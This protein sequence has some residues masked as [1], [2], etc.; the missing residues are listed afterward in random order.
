MNSPATRRAVAITSSWS[1]GVGST[2]AAIL[3][4]HE[5]PSTSMPMCRATIASVL[6]RSATLIASPGTYDH[7]HVTRLGGIDDCVAY[8][9]GILELAHQVDEYCAIEDLVRSTEV[10]ALTLLDLVGSPELR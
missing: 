5:I 2:P 10:I 6:G 9:P 8:G 7:K 3:V 4:M 1:S